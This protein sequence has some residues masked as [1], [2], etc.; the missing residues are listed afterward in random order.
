MLNQILAKIQSLPDALNK[1]TAWK[2]SGEK[3]IWTNGVFDLL[4][5]GHIKYLCE[6]RSLGDRLVVGLNSD[7]SVRRLKGPHRPINDQESRLYHMAALQ[8]TD[9]VV[10]FD[11]D[12]PIECILSLKPDVLAKGGDYDPRQ[13]VGG[14]EA[15]AWNGSVV[16]VPFESGFSSTEI[17]RKIKSIP[18]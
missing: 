6:A 11:Q 17:I 10:L 3:I 2:Q 4:H 12:T 18:G 13:V 15:L 9:L 8:M 5:L 16:I 7:A 1:V 14:K